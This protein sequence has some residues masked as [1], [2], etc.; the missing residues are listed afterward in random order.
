MSVVASLT[1]RG[2]AGVLSAL[3]GNTLNPRLRHSSA[4]SYNVLFTF[5]P[6]FFW[7][8]KDPK[9]RARGALRNFYV[10]LVAVEYRG[11]AL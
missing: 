1:P 7:V 3:Q 8:G 9:F 5:V 6:C 4:A 2:V 11:N 10:R